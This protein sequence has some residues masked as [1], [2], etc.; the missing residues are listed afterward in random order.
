MLL[1]RQRFLHCLNL[2]FQLC[3]FLVLDTDLDTDL[4]PHNCVEML[5][6]TVKAF[7]TDRG[8]LHLTVVQ[9]LTKLLLDARALDESSAN[10]L[11]VRITR[12]Q[13]KDPNGVPWL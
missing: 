6:R 4:V 1:F 5:D 7:G 8:P 9:D 11:C 13:K 10:I 12:N 2:A 3:C